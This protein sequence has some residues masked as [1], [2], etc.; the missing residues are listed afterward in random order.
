[1]LLFR[2]TTKD[3]KPDISP[4]EMQAAMPLWQKWIGDLAESG[5]LIST[6]PLQMEGRQVNA[7]KQVTD[8]PFAEV[9]EVVVGYLLLKADDEADALKISK[10]CPILTHSGGTVEIRETMSFPV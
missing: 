3:G 6:Q 8:G 9:K 2:N 10:N 5:K 7:A 1:M 4:E